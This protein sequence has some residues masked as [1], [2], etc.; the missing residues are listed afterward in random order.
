MWSEL[1]QQMA[2]T[3]VDVGGMAGQVGNGGG[4]TYQFLRSRANTIEAGTSEVL[5]NILAERV[6]GLPRSR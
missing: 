2:E 3:A 6:L 5:R 4:W 1:N